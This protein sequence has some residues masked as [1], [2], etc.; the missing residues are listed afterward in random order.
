MVFDDYLHTMRL[1]IVDERGSDEDTPNLMCPLPS[2]MP[3]GGRI[4]A[5]IHIATLQANPL[6]VCEW[7]RLGAAV[8]LQCDGHTPLTL[9]ARSLANRGSEMGSPAYLARAEYIARTLIEQHADVNYTFQD[10]TPLRYACYGKKWDLIT[11]LLKHGAHPLDDLSL[12]KIFPNPQ[13]RTHFRALVKAHPTGQ[14][15]PPRLCP[16]WSGKLLRDCH[17]TKQPYP[18]NFYCKCGSKKSYGK[19]CARRKVQVFE[20]FD[21][22]EGYIRQCYVRA[23]GSIGINNEWVT[24][25]EMARALYI[26]VP[27]EYLPPKGLTKE[28]AFHFLGRISMALLEQN[29]IDPAFAYAMREAQFLPRPQGVLSASLL[30]MRLR[31]SGTPR[32]TNI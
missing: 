11:L 8:D 6:C 12:T 5:R 25:D 1:G 2:D 14:K 16:C 27:R 23:V 29:A 4:V 24:T 3:G 28:E 7:I 13:D 19:C 32:L 9:A 26:S 31:S 30:A 18:A 21:Q 17:A 15:R 20:V 22:K 10:M